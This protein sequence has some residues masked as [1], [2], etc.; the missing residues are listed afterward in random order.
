M[1]F[2]MIV[3]K[4]QVDHG[5][6]DHAL[7]FRPQK[8]CET[9]VAVQDGVVAAQNGGALVHSLHEHTVGM[10]GPPEREH[11][12][13]ALAIYNNGVHIAGADRPEGLLGVAQACDQLATR[14]SRPCS[15]DA[16]LLPVSQPVSAFR[17][18]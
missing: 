4:Y 7:K 10:I 8:P 14:K 3:R 6:S 17:Q 15:W 11:F 12:L 5:R 9:T 1:Q 18:L 16:L 2:R 13:F